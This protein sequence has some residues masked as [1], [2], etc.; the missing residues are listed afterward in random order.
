MGCDG[1]CS[2][3]TLLAA[4]TNRLY[5]RDRYFGF[6]RTCCLCVRYR[7]PRPGI[8]CKG[9]KFIVRRG[10]LHFCASLCDGI[11]SIPLWS[12]SKCPWIFDASGPALLFALGTCWTYSYSL[13]DRKKRRSKE[14][15]YACLKE[16]RFTVGRRGTPDR[17]PEG[18][19]T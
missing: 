8:S 14:K 5:K 12:V 15:Q 16:M 18:N 1:R 4:G 6:Q 3:G 13:W 10:R 19:F 7:G 11:R 17:L 2:H 9:S